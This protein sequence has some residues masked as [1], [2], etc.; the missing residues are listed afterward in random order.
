MKRTVTYNVDVI[1]S[2]LALIDRDL[3]IKGNNNII[4]VGNIVQT[5]QNAGEIK[6]VPDDNDSK[7][8]EEMVVSSSEE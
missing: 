7:S 3:T 6:E 8:T 1:E 2:I 4:L 5:L